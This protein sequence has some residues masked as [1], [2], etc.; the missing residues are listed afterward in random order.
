MLYL[1]ILFVN[2]LFA[3]ATSTSKTLLRSNADN[4]RLLM[5][6]FPRNYPMGS[7]ISSDFIS[8]GIIELNVPGASD[9][10]CFQNNPLDEEL[11]GKIDSG[12]PSQFDGKFSISV[13]L[14]QI[15]AFSGV[16][17][18]DDGTCI[19]IPVYR[20]KTPDSSINDIDEKLDKVMSVLKDIYYYA[21]YSAYALYDLSYTN[22]YS[23]DHINDLVQSTNNIIVADSIYFHTILI[24]CAIFGVFFLL[25]QVLNIYINYDIRSRFLKI[26]SYVNSFLDGFAYND[27]LSIKDAAAVEMV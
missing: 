8:A 19:Y 25:L 14:K 24:T 22:M 21:E 2:F 9:F 4:M 23:V 18:G 12:D 11:F 3:T 27:Y 20:K 17:K 10:E 26:I 15:V 7:P 13:D 16:R 6:S 5:H 1:C